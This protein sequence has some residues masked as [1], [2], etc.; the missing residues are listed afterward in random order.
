MGAGNIV[1]DDKVLIKA[2]YLM[3]SNYGGAGDEMDGPLNDTIAGYF[4][5]VH[6]CIASGGERCAAK[7][8]SPL[9]LAC[10]Q[11]AAVTKGRDALAKFCTG[12]TSLTDPD[13]ISIRIDFDDKNIGKTMKN[14]WIS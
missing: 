7:R 10:N 11:W 12:S 3:F 1:P 6:I 2:K 4:H 5:R 14:K 13:K 9:K 8:Y